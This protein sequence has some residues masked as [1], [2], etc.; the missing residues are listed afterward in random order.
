MGIFGGTFDPVHNGHLG[1]ATECT[2]LFNL[3]RVIF[4]PV[5]QS[6]HK[7]HYQP[8]AA[9]HRVAMLNLALKNNPES[10]VEMLEIEKGGVSYT[11]ETLTLLKK[12]YPEWELYLILGA[13][14]FL[15]METWKDYKK[16]FKLCHLLVGTRPGIKLEISNKLSQTLRLDNTHIQENLNP[17][18]ISLDPAIG[19]SIRYYQ[20]PPKNISSREIRKKV[21]DEKDIRNLL[22]PEVDHYIMR[23]RL[24]RASPPPKMV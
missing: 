16:I 3:K 4:I 19:K 7:L 21:H 23:N 18:I 10:D 11:I 20:I 24:Y 2:K 8:T 6:P 5:S 22:P 13:D 15:V 1:L 12:K 17:L 14:S 9:N